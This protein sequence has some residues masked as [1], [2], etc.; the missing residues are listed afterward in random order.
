MATAKKSTATKKPVTKK[1]A[2]KRAAAKA[3][4]K[5]KVTKVRRAPSTK[6]VQSFRPTKPEQPFMTMQPS[7]Q[8]V[9]WLILA[10]LVLGLGFWV[11]NISMQVQDLYDQ[12]DATNQSTSN[13]T[14][15]VKK[16]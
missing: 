1:A 16:H 8:T 11:A 10:V 4:V 12:I 15:P 7:I 6:A 5:T 2:P 9:Y 13:I 14:T 3:T